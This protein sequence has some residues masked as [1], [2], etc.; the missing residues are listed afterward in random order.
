M[1]MQRGM[2]IIHLIPAQGWLA[3]YGSLKESEWLWTRPVVAWAVIE[4][5]IDGEARQR[6]DGL[7]S[8]GF[9]GDF[10][11][12]HVASEVDGFL[13]TYLREGEDIERYR[14][15]A[16]DILTMREAADKAPCPP[17]TKPSSSP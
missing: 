12:L 10:A 16:L 8:N 7:D 5:D 4:E 14:E 13:D 9:L 6:V 2:K 15:G 17:P 3:L 1:T 11:G